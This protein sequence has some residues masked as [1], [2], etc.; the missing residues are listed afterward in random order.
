MSENLQR[1]LQEALNNNSYDYSSMHGELKKTWEN[2][3]SYLYTLQK[4]YIEYEE[5]FFYSNNDESRNSKHIGHL[6]LDKFNRA[7][8][9]IDYDLIRV[10]TRE[11]YRTSNFYLREISIQKVI[12]HPEIFMKLPV[13]IID[14]QVIWDYK[15]KITKDCTSFILPFK[16]NFVIED[17]R[18]PDVSILRRGNSYTITKDLDI[19]GFDPSGDPINLNLEF[20]PAKVVKTRNVIMDA[21]RQGK[22]ITSLESEIDQLLYDYYTI[23]EIDD[24]KIVITAVSD[25]IVYLDHKVQVLLVDNVY[26]HRYTLHRTNLGLNMEENSIK[27]LYT[28]LGDTYGHLVPPK[29]EG[30][31]MISF[32][33][34]D[35]NYKGHELGTPLIPAEIRDDYIYANISDDLAEFLS[36]RTLVFYISV[37]FFSRLKMHTF[38]DGTNSTIADEDNTTS[39]MVIEENHLKPYAMPI[40]I[41]NF[42]V[43]KNPVG[44]DKGFEIVKNKDALELYYPNI[45]KIVDKDMQPGD[46]YRIYYFYYKGYDLHY[47]PIHHFYYEF[48]DDVFQKPLEEIVDKLYRGKMDLSEYFTEEQT[49]SFNEVFQ[50]IIRYKYYYHLYGEIDFLHRYLSEDKNIGKEPVEYK[51]ETLRDWIRVEP[52]V[53][54]EYVLEQK[55]RGVVY[56]FFTN[57]IDLSSR[58]RMNTSLELGT[59]VTFE[60]ERY[61]FAISNKM[62]YPNPLN[63]RCFVDGIFVMDLYQDRKLFMD[64]IYIPSSMVT[65]DSYIELEI[66]QEYG[67]EEEVTFTSMEDT[68]SISIIE[69][70]KNITPTIADLVFIDSTDDTTRYDTNFFDI[71]AHYKEGDFDVK[72]VSPKKPIRFT[73]LTN[74]TIRPNED[75]VLNIPFKIRLSKIASGERYVIKE[76]GQQRFSLISDKFGFSSE[77]IRIFVNGRI[78][79]RGRYFI[80]TL[81]NYPLVYL[82][83]EYNV[84][85]VVYID[86]TPYRYK[87]IYY[88][89]ELSKDTTIIDL[90][91]YITKPFDI[92]YY[93]VYMNGRKLSIP[94]VYF[95]DPWSITLTNLKSNYNL[96]IFEKERDYEYF[97]L[98]YKEHIYYFSIEDLLNQNFVSED[99][100]N[101]LIKRIIDSQKDDR[102]NIYPN[103]NDEKREDYRDLSL[104]MR[105]YSFYHDE[106]IPKTF[107]NPDTKQTSTAVMTELYYPIYD[108]YLTSP[109]EET[110]DPVYKER[111][112]YYPE[113][114]TLNPDIDLVKESEE[115]NP[116]NKQLV[117]SVG[118]LGEI[119]QEKLDTVVVI[120]TKRPVDGR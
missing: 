29:Q 109:Y 47:T 79:P 86:I 69:P 85:D 42:I 100:R 49:I 107:Y 70:D 37:V 21:T 12:D 17:K 72:P 74:F 77:Y 95:V 96:L 54:R 11:E 78:L 43:V 8:F 71:I 32:H 23:D 104:Y 57:T 30:M 10:Y 66:L 16:R 38:Y 61:V 33:F 28:T 31:Y 110:S 22:T 67:I 115:D 56:Q 9:D 73:R 48:L 55:H 120:D 39:L 91:G 27:I 103:T 113:V 2:S 20:L 111:R 19:F 88:Q 46:E 89:E 14:D 4:S 24:D 53:L 106:L 117:Y 112:C 52:F 13:V 75:T 59:N 92:R 3:F 90:K 93:D 83:D 116:E 45:Y 99:E 65:E 35:I 62:V 44:K 81:Y 50:K 105:I 64:Y 119:E 102:V 41:E 36:K 68:K 80:N 98:N 6:Y 63:I 118:H 34:P 60:E 94:N 84:G 87:Q 76:P 40:P 101:T 26:Y 58:S 7:S 51:D 5:L 114:I 108:A 97:G 15:I 82:M 25:D 1:L 18:N